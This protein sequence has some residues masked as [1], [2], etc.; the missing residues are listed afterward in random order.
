[1]SAPKPPT[2]AEV[3]ALIEK[4]K[5][6]GPILVDVNEFNVILAALFGPKKEEGEKPC[7]PDSPDTHP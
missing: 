3:E 2:P 1:V 7:T 4:V 5:S 6:G